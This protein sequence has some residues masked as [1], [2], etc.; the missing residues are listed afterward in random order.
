MSGGAMISVL[1]VVVALVIGGILI[2]VTDTRVTTALGYFWRP[3]GNAQ[4][5][6]G[7]DFRSVRSTVAWSH[8]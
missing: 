8:L 6:L 3:H 4:G 5:H 2:A 7:L 1:A